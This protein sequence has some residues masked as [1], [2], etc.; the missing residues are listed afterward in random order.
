[1]S[2]NFHHLAE[3]FE[4]MGLPPDP[5]AITAYI[6]NHS[7]LHSSIR[8]EE[9][10]FWSPSQAELLHQ[11]ILDDAEWVG[12]VDQLNLALRATQGLEPNAI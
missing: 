9:A 7:P 12:M 3:L 1:M 8:L 11:F 10:D 2:A 6:R 4:E 5:Y